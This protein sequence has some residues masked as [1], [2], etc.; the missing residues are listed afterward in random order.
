ML[1]VGLKGVG[2]IEVGARVDGER[3][4][5]GH[6]DGGDDLV[7]SLDRGNVLRRGVRNDTHM[8]H[9]VAPRRVQANVQALVGRDLAA[10]DEVRNDDLRAA[11]RHGEQLLNRCGVAHAGARHQS[12]ADGVVGTN[13]LWRKVDDGLCAHERR[14]GSVDPPYY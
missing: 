11:K 10:D 1:P 3:V 12:A 5:I 14:R 7:R 9:G 2:L 4:E 8:H 13:S 6:A